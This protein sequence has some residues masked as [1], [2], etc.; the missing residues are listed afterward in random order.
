MTVLQEHSVW[1]AQSLGPNLSFLYTHNTVSMVILFLS[2][3]WKQQVPLKPWYLP[4]KQDGITSQKTVIF[5]ATA[6]RALNLTIKKA[7]IT[8]STRHS[9]FSGQ[10][11][12][13]ATVQAHYPSYHTC[14]LRSVTDWCISCVCEFSPLTTNPCHR[15]TCQ[16]CPG[17]SEKPTIF[18]QIIFKW[19]QVET[20]WKPVLPSKHQYITTDAI[21]SQK[22]CTKWLTLKWLLW[23]WSL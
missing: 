16:K 14:S 3:R 18:P 13:L 22:S 23:L 8:S 19:P 10:V 17:C 12:L 5:I 7:C 9:M 20:M 21:H 1:L 15:T 4:T 6:M 2:W 11:V